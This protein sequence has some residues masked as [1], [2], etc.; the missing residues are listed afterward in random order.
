LTSASHL[1]RLAHDEPRSAPRAVGSIGAWKRL[2]VNEA[3]LMVLRMMSR[4]TL[5]VPSARSAPENDR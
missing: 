2:P 1:K 5:G 3:S 4:G